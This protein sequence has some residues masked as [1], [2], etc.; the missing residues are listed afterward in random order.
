MKV[1]NTTTELSLAQITSALN[2][3]LSNKQKVKL[4]KDMSEYCGMIDMSYIEEVLL[5]AAKTRLKSIKKDKSLYTRNKVYFNALK[6]I[7]KYKY[8]E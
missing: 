1:H 5:M 8:A 4:A 6:A 2:I 7:T 3:E